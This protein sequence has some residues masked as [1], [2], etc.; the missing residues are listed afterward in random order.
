MRQAYFL[1]FLLLA[2]SI[3]AVTGESEEGTLFAW[4]GQATTVELSG[5]WDWDTNISLT[6]NNDAWMTYIELE[7]GMYCYKFIV[8]GEYIFDPVNRYRGYCE[9]V[10]NSIM[11]VNYATELTQKIEGD[12]LIIGGAVSS[13]NQ[14]YN[15]VQSGS[16]WQLNIDELPAGKHTIELQSGESQ[17][18]LAVFWTGD[19]ANFQWEDALIYMV[20]TDR[21]VNGNSSN[22][23]P[24]TG[25]EPEADWQGGDFEGVKQKIE[26]GY[27]TDL[28]VNAIWISPANTNPNGS[29]I[30]G[31]G[32]HQVSGYHGYWPVQPRQ[33]DARFGGEQEL[34][35]MV[36][37][38]HQAGIRVMADFVVNHV[39]EDHLYAQEHPDWFNQGCLCGTDACDWTERRLDCLFMDYLPDL[40]WK[41]RNA[42][43]Q[44]ISDA[45]WWI[46]RFD[47]DGLRIDAVKHVDDLAITNLAIRVAERFEQT[48]TD[49]Y[50]KGETAMGW[51][52]HSLEENTEQYAT[53]NRYMSSDGLD[54]QADFVLYHAVVDNVFTSGNMDY[55]HL[56]YW[57]NRSQDQYV[58]GAIMVPYIGSHDSPR[59]I[60]RADNSGDQ[61][62]QWA[63]QSLPSTPQQSAYDKAKQAFAW[64]LTTPGAPMIYMGDEYGQAGGADPDNRRMFETNLDQSQLDLLNFSKDLANIR[65]ENEALR[66]GV[67]STY[68]ASENLLAYEMTTPDDSILVILNRGQQTALSSDYDEILFG[69]ATLSQSNLSIPA[70]SIQIFSKAI[71][72]QPVD[73]NNTIEDNETVEDNGT[74]DDN[75][76]IDDNG[77]TEDN[78]TI[79]DINKTDDIAIATKDDWS[80]LESIRNILVMLVA[81]CLILLIGMS[82]K[83]GDNH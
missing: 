44:V 23:G 7:P 71:Q 28:G 55:N 66:R 63:E 49:I 52:G 50:L 18:S 82:R 31:D 4:S 25:A 13:P 22:D 58:D 57:T 54:G 47:L 8:D 45:L 53:I 83:T 14:E 36:E 5:E 27:F 33:V 2:L 60:S 37:A 48:G 19:Q 24:A 21:F 68:Q 51:S 20:M 43:E 30:A 64:L 1:V 59:F 15:F 62:N 10:E 69:Q 26:D 77:T 17:S 39:H 61:W 42:S 67:Y 73:G 3:P 11:R 78:S 79:D 32:V 46:E 9:G 34:E 80:S 35:Q 6:Q 29:Y 16:D 74:V 76:T 65:L 75:G 81:I 72:E 41:N 12:L 56:D 38:A 40:D 70:N